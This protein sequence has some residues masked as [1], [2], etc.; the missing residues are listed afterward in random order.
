MNSAAKIASLEAE[1]ASLRQQVQALEEKVMLLLKTLEQQK[2][3][4]DS[5]NSHNP[6][7]QDKFKPRRNSKS[8]RPKST[9]KSGGQK[10]HKG[11]TLFQKA[12]PDEI[13]LL[14]S[15][16]C[17]LCGED[18]REQLHEF[19][20]KRQVVEIPPIKP[21]YIE[22]QLHECLC[23]CGN[24]QRAAYPPNVVAPIQFGGSIVALVSY[25]NVFQYVPYARLKQLFQ[26]IYQLPISEGSIENL[27]KKGASKALPVYQTIFD[28]IKKAT[29]LGAD[30]TGAK[31]NG[32]KWWIWVWQNV[33]NTFLSASDNRG[34]ATVE[35]LFPEG[36]PK[37]IIGSDRWAAQLKIKSKDK[38]LCFPHLQRDL[39]FLAE[40]EKADWAIDFK[41][42]LKQALNLRHQAV[43]RNQ[44][45]KKEE[46]EIKKLEQQLN[47][48]LAH[49]IIKKDFPLTL[50][51]QKA[52]IKH[53]NHLFPCLFNLEVPPDNNAS[54]RAVRNVKVKQKISGQFKSGQDTFCTLRSIIDT[55]R[56]R[57][58]D[59]LFFLKRIMAI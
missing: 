33:K 17:N 8:L 47:T 14:Q 46:D 26:D 13:H 27:L 30:E 44:P 54:E 16:Y 50:T 2:V 41:N 25:F 48:L 22:Y 49:P 35:A 31:V 45:F 10:G 58:L 40:K 28:N 5:H 59:V 19:V 11:F 56:K 51:F 1:N 24:I 4:K 3:K 53:R 39:I 21:I 32:E 36:L 20:S 18:L 34:F 9:R 12:T 6:P 38:Q 23:N 42:L 55:L 43:E 57:E 29:Y 15:D 7:S 37:A 52:M